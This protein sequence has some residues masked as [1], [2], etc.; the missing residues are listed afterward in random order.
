MGEE[1][2]NS[3]IDCAQNYQRR[4]RVNYLRITLFILTSFVFLAVLNWSVKVT[5]PGVFSSWDIDRDELENYFLSQSKKGTCIIGDSSFLVGKR[6]DE[7][8]V[9]SLLSNHSH[10][11]SYDGIRTSKNSGEIVTILYADKSGIIKKVGCL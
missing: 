10:V 4:S 5:T 2:V 3:R 6:A 1:G 11:L 8:I 9:R 7:P